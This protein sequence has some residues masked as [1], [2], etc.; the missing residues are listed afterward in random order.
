MKINT[1]IGAK[2]QVKGIVKKISIVIDIEDPKS[3]DQIEKK[4]NLILY[5]EDEMRDVQTDNERLKKKVHG[6]G[7]QLQLE[8]AWL[9]LNYSAVYEDMREA[10]K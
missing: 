3:I 8:R 7:N 9:S 4:N 1:R 6:L 10:L 5:T 2:L